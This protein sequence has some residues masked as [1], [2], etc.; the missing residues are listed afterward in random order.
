MQLWLRKIATVHT[1]S[2]PRAVKLA[3]A[4]LAATFAV[5]LST[6]APAPASAAT[7]GT[8]KATPSSGND[9]TVNI[10][11]DSST[12]CPAD[13]SDTNVIITITGAGFPTDSNAVGNQVQSLYPTNAS[14]GLTIPLGKTWEVLAQ[15]QGANLPL[16]GTATLT[17]KC[18]DIFN[19]VSFGEF[20]LQVQFTPTTGAHFDY[21]AIGGTPTPTP[22]PT[23]TNTQTH[24]QT[25]T[26]TD[27]ETQSETPTPTPTDSST[28]APTSGGSSADSSISTT[29][30][31]L[32]HTGAN[33]WGLAVAGI[34]LTLIGAVFIGIS[35][36]SKLLT[37]DRSGD[38]G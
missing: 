15:S 17:M 2:V 12:A 21:A 26:P 14:G 28:P 34:V 36:R 33:V 5:G 8:M 10:A 11:F 37:F 27:T 31:S 20:P 38:D 7:I 3:A 29:V 32:A 4:A 25:P 16:T 35:R 22:T 23:P 13:A 18:I 24:S 1:R 19:S 6:L 30:G 9:A